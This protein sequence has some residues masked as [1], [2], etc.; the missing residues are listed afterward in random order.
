MQVSLVAALDLA[1]AVAQDT[2]AQDSV[3]QDSVEVQ[4]TVAAPS[5]K[6]ASPPSAAKDAI[7]EKPSKPTQ[8]S[9]PP[10]LPATRSLQTFLQFKP[11]MV[12]YSSQ[13]AIPC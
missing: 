3:A 4:D 11:S 7:K 9:F 12:L 13:T 5:A 8:P 2:V 10:S 1:M 6:P